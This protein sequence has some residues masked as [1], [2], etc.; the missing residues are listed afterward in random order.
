MQK[1]KYYGY[2]S[3]DKLTLLAHAA[4]Q[5]RVRYQ[6]QKTRTQEYVKANRRV[7]KSFHTS[8]YSWELHD[9]SV[10]RFECLHTAVDLGVF[11]LDTRLHDARVAENNDG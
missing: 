2:T 10:L 9:N 7:T 5:T 11:A 3:W 8:T 4:L 1:G 6:S